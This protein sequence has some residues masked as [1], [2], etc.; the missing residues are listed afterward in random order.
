LP[1]PARFPQGLIRGNSRPAA[2]TLD[3]NAEAIYARRTSRRVGFTEATTNPHP[4]AAVRTSLLRIAVPLL[5]ALSA[6]HLLDQTDFEPARPAR[7]VPPPVPDP[8]SRAALVTIEFAKPDPDYRGALAAAIPVVEARRPGV[9]YDVVAVVP[10]AAGAAAGHTR[11]AE[12][13]TAI[14]AAGVNPARIQLGLTLDPGRKIPQVRVY[15][16]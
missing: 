1:T 6:C 5:L 14:E 4:E 11:A 16:R 3:P 12:V 13:M 15:L 10:D 7:S 8:E 9:L 2:R